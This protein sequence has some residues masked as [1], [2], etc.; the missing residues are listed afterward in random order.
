[1]VGSKYVDTH[2]NVPR[3]KNEP[4]TP[5]TEKA[6]HLFLLHIICC[7][8]EDDERGYLLQVEA[9]ALAA[10]PQILDRLRPPREL[11]TLVR[12]RSIHH[13]RQDTVH[14]APW[15]DKHHTSSCDVVSV[16]ESANEFSSSNT[17][18]GLDVARSRQSCVQY[19]SH[20]NY[21]SCSCP[22]V[23]LHFLIFQC[24]LVCQT[25]TPATTI[26]D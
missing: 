26:I 6:G 25:S 9:V 17:S 7:L 22:T 12:Q 8:H 13:R 21:L 15:F 11:Q 4:T 16:L 1:M 14:C 2:T 24:T 20:R 5:S 3:R 18:P 10:H 19:T 23:I